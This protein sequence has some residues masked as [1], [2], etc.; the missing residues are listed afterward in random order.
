MTTREWSVEIKGTL[1]I[2]MQQSYF[3][4]A[5]LFHGRFSRNNKL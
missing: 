4:K 1:K 3:L 5:I 2:V